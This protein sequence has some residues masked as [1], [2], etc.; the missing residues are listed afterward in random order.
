[1]ER[2]VVAVVLVAIVAAVSVV[3]GRRRQADAPSQP[4]T[5]PVP[6]QLDRNDFEAQ[7]KPWL[8]ALFTSATCDGCARVVGIA[9][10]LDSPQVGVQVIP[11]QDRKDLHDRYGVEAVPCLALADEEGVVRYGFVGSTTSATDIWAAVAEA[12]GDRP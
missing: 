11:W 1:V 3:M 7:D 2:L 9:E 4:R 5:W 8:V 6:A 12:R 10:A